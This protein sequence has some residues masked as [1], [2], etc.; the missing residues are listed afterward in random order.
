MVHYAKYAMEDLDI[1]FFGDDMIE[2][3]SGTKVLGS[4][5]ADGMEEY[6]AKTFTKT[7][8]GKLNGLA[9][10]SYGDTVRAVGPNDNSVD[11]LTDADHIV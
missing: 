11:R 3:L 2:E 6:F 1:V 7:G 10:G 8:G 9:L 4:E 5:I